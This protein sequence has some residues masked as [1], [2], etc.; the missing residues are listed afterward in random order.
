MGFV[1]SS[2]LRSCRSGRMIGAALLVVVAT[3][4]LAP[5]VSG[6][7]NESS[8]PPP[9]LV[10]DKS[11]PPPGNDDKSSATGVA[12][13]VPAGKTFSSEADGRTTVTVS[14]NGTLQSFTS[15]DNAL[16]Q[17]GHYIAPRDGYVLCLASNNSYFEPYGGAGGQGFGPA[18]TSTSSTG[19]F[20]VVRTT[21]DGALRLT[22]EFSFTG[23]AKR[24]RVKMTVTNL[25]PT[26]AI[27]VRVRRQSDFDVDSSGR[28]AFAANQN[29]WLRT[30]DSVLALNDPDR[31]P[32]A[33]KGEHGMLLGHEAS[34]S[35]DIDV[36]SVVATTAF[37]P[38]CSSS[39]LKTPQA[40]PVDRSAA[41]SYF[42]GNIDPGKS[43]SVTMAYQRI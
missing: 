27:S 13:L 37:E 14:A 7:A 16:A 31:F 9:G 3:G 5:E 41:L 38:F 21:S 22:Q 36:T 28:D 25:T 35:S 34:S 17:S 15:P 4:A 29:S 23:S 24:L 12:Q 11:S 32:G 1:S 26:L 39:S 40:T 33:E 18:T 30:N 19:A 6:A 2:I 42:V 10:D 43:K 8:S 20:Q